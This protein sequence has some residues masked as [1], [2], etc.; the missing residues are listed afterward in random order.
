MRIIKW[1]LGI[2]A[3][4]AV[5]VLGGGMFLPSQ[6][7]VE[8]SVVIH[9]PPEALHALV[10]APKAWGRWAVW[11]QRD[12]A[13]QITFSGPESGVGASWAWKSKTEGDG[14]MTLVRADEVSA[15]APSAIDF[16]LYFPDMDA[17]SL[18]SIIFTP[19]GKLTTVR[20]TTQMNLG[21]NPLMHWMS[22]F[23]DKLVGPDF[24]AGLANMKALAEKEQ[25]DKTGAV[26]NE[27][28]PDSRAT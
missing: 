4:L 5:V 23:A 20:W 10:V 8:R 25:A 13:M 27:G 7:M 14:V 18:G 12:P 11:N 24:E 15:S 6:A 1:L 9:A 3:A 28:V 16:K 2:V 19:N 21:A 17:T 26:T 22:L